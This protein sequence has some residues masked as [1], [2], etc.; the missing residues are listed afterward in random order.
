VSAAAA[1]PRGLA[2]VGARHHQESGLLPGRKFYHAPAD[3]ALA[4]SLCGRPAA[5]VCAGSLLPKCDRHARDF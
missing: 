5:Y 4:C 3:A 1:R 2:P